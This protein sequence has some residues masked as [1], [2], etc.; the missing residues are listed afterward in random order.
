MYPNTPHDCNNN[1]LTDAES[2]LLG[3]NPCDE[4]L[5]AA[6][7]ASRIGPYPFFPKDSNQ[8]GIYDIWEDPDREGTERIQIHPLNGKME[9]HIAVASNLKMQNGEF[10]SLVAPDGDYFFAGHDEGQF[11]NKDPEKADGQSVGGIASTVIP[12]DFLD[13]LP[14]TEAEARAMEQ[15]FTSAAGTDKPLDWSMGRVFFRMSHVN[16]SHNRYRQFRAPRVA[17]WDNEQAISNAETRIP[18][19]QAQIEAL[20]PEDPQYHLKK[21]NFETQIEAHEANI[22][23][24]EFILPLAQ[25]DRQPF[26]DSYRDEGI[27]IFGSDEFLSWEENFLTAAPITRIPVDRRTITSED[28]FWNGA[29]V[30]NMFSIMRIEFPMGVPE[31][32]V[33]RKVELGALDMD[34]PVEVANYPRLPSAAV[35]PYRV[36]DEHTVEVRLTGTGSTAKDY[37]NIYQSRYVGDPDINSGSYHILAIGHTEEDRFVDYSHIGAPDPVDPDP[38]DP[39]PVSPDPEEPSKKSSSGGTFGWIPLLGLAALA[40]RRR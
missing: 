28:P 15:D 4:N 6:E 8:N 31:G 21:A 23:K 10:I 19:L 12:P 14:K 40:L 17:I 34:P 29:S 16:T 38:V 30:L 2:R 32:L 13:I 7:V 24:A 5:T 11:I 33:I 35:V 1:G 37:T 27:E 20:D 25:A 9:N 39:D 3:L 22:Q 26:E 18:N 36:V